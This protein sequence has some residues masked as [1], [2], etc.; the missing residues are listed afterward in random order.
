MKIIRTVLQGEGKFTLVIDMQGK[1]ALSTADMPGLA[2]KM[3]AALP[4]IFPD[5]ASPIVHTCGGGPAGGSEHPFREE[6]ER[7]MSIPH[8]LEHVLLHLLSR[9]TLCCSAFCGQRSADIERG[10]TTH[11]Y[12]V[13]DCPSELEAVVAVEIAFGL[14][15]AWIEGR[16]V[17]VDSHAV[18]DRL[19]QT[20]APMVGTAAWR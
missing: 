7:G 5:T 1:A 15:S 16:T 20:I 2:S 12:L 17:T 4:G 6:L 3:A 11:Y 14:V 19:R 8:L 18:L 13:L 9:R 10:I